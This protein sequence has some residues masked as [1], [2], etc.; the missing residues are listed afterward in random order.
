MLRRLSSWWATRSLLIGAVSVGLDLATGGTIL[1]FGGPTRLA[2]MGGTTVGSTWTYF[3]N[4][5]LAFRDHEEPVARSGIKF[6]VMQAVMSV[7][8]GQV[9]VWLRDGYGI[10]YVFAKLMADVM[11]VTV[12]QLL[13]MRYV[14]FPQKKQQSGDP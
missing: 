7:L 12:P 1:W 2:A 3:A 13:L 4:R 11:V 5:H 14:I 10:P 8:H 9:V 6:F